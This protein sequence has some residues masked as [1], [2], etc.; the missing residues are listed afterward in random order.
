MLESTYQLKLIKKIEKMLP[1]CIVLKNDTQYRQGI[2]DLS[3]FYR[4]RWAF[5]E[6]KRSASE[7]IQPNQDYYVELAGQMSF[8]AFIFPENE[9]DVLYELQQ[10][11]L[12]RRQARLSKS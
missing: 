4:E 8:A 9:E 11:L 3:I 6:V 10:A 12:P 2:P 7:D 5:L 1:G